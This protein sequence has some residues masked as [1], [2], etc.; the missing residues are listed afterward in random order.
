MTSITYGVLLSDQNKRIARIK[1]EFID[2]TFKLQEDIEA[3]GRNQRD[4]DLNGIDYKIDKLADKVERHENTF[5]ALTSARR[6]A[7]WRSFNDFNIKHEGESPRCEYCLSDDT[8][9]DTKYVD[10]A[11]STAPDRLVSQC[12]KCGQKSTLWRFEVMNVIE[13]NKEIE[14]L[15]DKSKISDGSHTFEELYHHRAILFSIICNTYK[16]QSWKSWKH[17]DGTMFE[18]YFVVGVTTEQGEYSYHYHKDYWKY[19]KVKELSYAPVWDGH[20]P[21][22]IERLFTLL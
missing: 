20:K 2:D 3:L 14:L 15:E 1:K 17:D 8:K 4:I 13:I 12:C 18:D 6:V 7:R 10:I 11:G 21:S 19:F 22:D 9:Y 16:N 5:K